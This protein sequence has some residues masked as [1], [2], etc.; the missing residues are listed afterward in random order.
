MRRYQTRINLRK[1]WYQNN[2]DKLKEKFNCD[3]GGCYTLEN[4]TKHQKTKKH[5]LYLDQQ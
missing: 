3:C 2:K 5:L 1:K 4:K